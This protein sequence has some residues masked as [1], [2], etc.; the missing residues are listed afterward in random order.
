[1]K[2]TETLLYSLVIT[3]LKAK[4]PIATGFRGDRAFGRMMRGRPRSPQHNLQIL[5]LT[6]DLRQSLDDFLRQVDAR[7]PV[8]DREDRERD[9][10]EDANDA[11]Q[12]AR[13]EGEDD[14]VNP[15]SDSDDEEREPDEAERTGKELEHDVNCSPEKRPV[16]QGFP[17]LHRSRVVF[18]VAV[19]GSLIGNQDLPAALRASSSRLFRS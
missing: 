6:E 3:V 13:R 9:L 14:A 7:D 19:C 12:H 2:S 15:G 10:D 18:V 17:M 5:L 4:A 11:Q 1:M 16:E 8:R